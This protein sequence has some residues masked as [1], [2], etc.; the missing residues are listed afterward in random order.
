MTDSYDKLLEKAKDVLSS[1]TKN[2]DR[3]KIPEPEIIREGK[4]TIIRN[5]QD[6]IDIINR[7]PDQVIKFL[8]RE[9]GTNIVQNGRRLIINKK[10]TLEEL[11]EKMNEYINTYV[12]CYECGSLDTEIQKSGRVSLLVCKACGAQHPIHT[13]KEFKEEEGIEEGKEYTV[14]ISEVGSSGEGRASF[15]GFTIFVPGTKKGE[16]VKVKIKKIKNDVAIAEVVS[17]TSDKK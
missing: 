1:S 2:I 15:R 16:T 8:T 4:A 7:D 11:Q 17:R 5:F 3:L 12:R 6:I 9:L 13:V 10:V 14:E